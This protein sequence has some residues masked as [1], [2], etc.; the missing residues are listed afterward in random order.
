MF[1]KVL[2]NYDIQFSQPSQLYHDPFNPEM[3]LAVLQSL[4]SK[5]HL[6]ISSRL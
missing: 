1:K 6:Q 3:G 5:C 4:M 2:Q